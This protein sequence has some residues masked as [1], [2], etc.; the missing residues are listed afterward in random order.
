M[1]KIAE[2]YECLSGAVVLYGSGTSEGKWFYREWDKENKKY[3]QKQIP[4]AALV[5]EALSGAIDAAF[6]IKQ[7]KEGNAV[8][9]GASSKQTQ[10]KVWMIRT[11][12][13]KTLLP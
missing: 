8:Y 3:R 7:E 10:I 2:K 13:L 11:D 9:V 4:D 12:K 6:K 5:T 1:P